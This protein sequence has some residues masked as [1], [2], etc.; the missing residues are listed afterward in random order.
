MRYIPMR[1]GRWR[2]T[3]SDPDLDYLEKRARQE[4]DIAI[5]SEDNCVALA[6]LRMADEYERR[7]QA[8]KDARHPI[9]LHA[10]PH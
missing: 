2:D 5:V 4:R 3:M 1:G 10:L 8:S 7:A 9:R 6:H